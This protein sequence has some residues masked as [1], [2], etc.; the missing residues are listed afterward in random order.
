MPLNNAILN[1]RKYKIPLFGASLFTKKQLS[2]TY[3]FMGWNFILFLPQQ[4]QL[5]VRLSGSTFLSR[6]AKVKQGPA[7]TWFRHSVHDYPLLLF[8]FKKKRTYSF[9]VN[10]KSISSPSL[11]KNNSGFLSFARKE[12][13]Q[14]N[15][16][17]ARAGRSLLVILRSSTYPVLFADSTGILEITGPS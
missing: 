11:F 4:L 12:I 13:F 3:L 17:S 1:T 2:C 16:I 7:R 9:F 6:L 10:A 14:T 15:Y 5:C 8:F